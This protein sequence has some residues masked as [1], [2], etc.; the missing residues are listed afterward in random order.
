M[1]LER[2]DSNKL[3]TSIEKSFLSFL[4]G[5]DKCPYKSDSFRFLV[6]KSKISREMIEDFFSG[7][8]NNMLIY[9]IDNLYLVFYNNK[10]RVEINN[11]VDMFNEDAGIK[12]LFFEGFLVKNTN[13]NHFVKFLD[14]FFN[15]FDFH[16]S[17]SK[18]SDLIFMVNDKKEEL[19]VVKEALLDK[20]LN[21][22]EFS[23]MLKAL[24]KNNL[25]VS[26][27]ANDLYMHR[28]TLNNKLNSFEDE[29]TLSIQNFIDAVS[30]YELL[31]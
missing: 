27:A 14:T 5:N 18:V 16:N 7:L 9:R 26:K 28:N 29:T 31:K 17:Y 30:L 10:D 23:N 8:L 22:N 3:I 25:N 13:L 4:K 24:F 15:Y 19:L 1:I 21:D 2:I 12:S 6:I 11:F 20:Y